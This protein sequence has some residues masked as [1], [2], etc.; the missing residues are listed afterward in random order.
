MGASSHGA[1]IEWPKVTLG[2]RGAVQMPRPHHTP[3]SWGLTVSPIPFAFRPL[4]F[5]P[6]L[7]VFPSSPLPR[8]LRRGC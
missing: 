6:L 3:G 7:L 1:T 2:A 5:S 8:R 4:L